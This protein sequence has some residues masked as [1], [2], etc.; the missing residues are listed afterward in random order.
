MQ[1]TANQQF[2]NLIYYLVI[3]HSVN[4]P[5]RAFLQ[6]LRS[7]GGHFVGICSKPSEILANEHGILQS[8]Y[9]LTI[10][11]VEFAAKFPFAK[12]RHSYGLPGH[13]PDPYLWKS[14]SEYIS[15]SR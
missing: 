7:H 14:D 3:R 6:Q 2:G 11:A 8:E 4:R 1:A 12:P 13:Y 5:S 15:T 10:A 9:R